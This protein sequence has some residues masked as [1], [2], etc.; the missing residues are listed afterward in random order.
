MDLLDL[1]LA[2]LNTLL[3]ENQGKRM[4]NIDRYTR[5]RST[6]VK[7]ECRDLWKRL[8]AEGEDILAAIALRK[9]E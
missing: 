3:Q 8:S 9:G 1:D 4:A 7:A 6:V 2:A 5:A